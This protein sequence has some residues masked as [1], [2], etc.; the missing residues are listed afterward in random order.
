MR[1]RGLGALTQEYR[2]TDELA[3]AEYR[4][5]RTTIAAR[6]H[7]R[8]GVFAG[9][10]LAWAALLLA[11]L[12]WLP[13]PLLAVVPLLLLVGTFEAIRSLHFGV[14]RIGR[15]L[16]VF[17]EERAEGLEAWGPE[18]LK[19]EGS[20]VG[21]TPPA[22]ERAVVRVGGRVPGA[23]GHPLFAPIYTLATTINLLAVALP[24]PGPEEWIPLVALHAAFAGWLFYVDRGV[25][26]QRAHDEAR[27][28][29]IRD[30]RSS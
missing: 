7:L 9:G 30:G 11:V 20:E 22:W 19:A 17:F 3:L 6:G 21:M 10:L 15:Y 13:Q 1:T 29:S 27:F 8:V 26:A 16:Q 14:E 25:R 18:G 24:G 23:A 28:R 4:A 2:K 12:A 5:L